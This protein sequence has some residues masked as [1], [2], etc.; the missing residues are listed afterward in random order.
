MGTRQSRALL[1][2]REQLDF[3]LET[4]RD[5]E[6]Q[7][8][9]KTRIVFVVPDYYAR[10]PKACVGGPRPCE[11]GPH[12][13]ALEC[14]FLAFLEQLIMTDNDRPQVDLKPFET[15]S[16]ERRFPRR[17]SC[18]SLCCAIGIGVDWESVLPAWFRVLSAT[19]G[20]AEY[21]QRI[22]STVR[23]HNEQGRGKMLAVARKIATPMQRQALPKP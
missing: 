17:P 11:S 20:P 8:R 13:P 6:N 4:L 22:A 7:L 1:P 3:C 19:C 15:S 14:N 9:G 12:A 5:A 18:L 21:A 2:S 16:A 23:C 10:Y